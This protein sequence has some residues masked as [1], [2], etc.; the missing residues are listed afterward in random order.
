VTESSRTLTVAV[1]S[2]ALCVCLAVILVLSTRPQVQVAPSPAAPARPPAPDFALQDM[3]GQTVR[4][5]ALRGQVVLVDFW[6][7]WCGPCRE[8]LPML[9]QLVQ[10]NESRGVRFV[11]ISEDDPPAQIPDVAAFAKQVPGLERYAV[12]GDPEVERL[13][14]VDSLP[15]L[16]VLDRQ[17]GLVDALVGSR[18]APEITE[19]IEEA[20]RGP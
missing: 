11:A 20:L 6:A 2:L 3:R 9:V 19:A 7:T 12:Y 13:F 14:G 17:G 10:R 5:S 16:F 18:G 4:L 15:T 1:L 8:E